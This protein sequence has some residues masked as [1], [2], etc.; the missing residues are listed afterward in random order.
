MKGRL[1]DPGKGVLWPNIDLYVRLS[2]MSGC[3]IQ[4]V[5]LRSKLVSFLVFIWMESAATKYNCSALP[6]PPVE[7]RPSRGKGSNQGYILPRESSLFLPKPRLLKPS[8]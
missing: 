7:E 2:S 4:W 8:Y 3:L 6:T 1:S 5:S